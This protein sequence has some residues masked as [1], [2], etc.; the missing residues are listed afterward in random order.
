ML[1]LQKSKLSLALSPNIGF[2]CKKSCNQLDV[3]PFKSAS[4][5]LMH[6][7]ICTD[8][9]IMVLSYYFHSFFF[10]FCAMSYLNFILS[11]FIPSFPLSLF[12]MNNI[13]CIVLQL[14]FIHCKL[15]LKAIRVS[16]SNLSNSFW[17]LHDIPC[18]T[19][20]NY[21]DMGDVWILFFFF[22][23]HKSYCSECPSSCLLVHI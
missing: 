20:F 11:V 9:K 3:Y 6:I 8:R 15:T 12:F 14:V 23:Y 10:L 4:Y 16:T 13:N 17:L 1:P 7:Y 5:V 22:C 2:P 21:L 18:L 19:L